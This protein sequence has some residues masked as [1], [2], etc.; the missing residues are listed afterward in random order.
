MFIK[1][2]SGTIAEISLK[3]EKKK[4]NCVGLMILFQDRSYWQVVIMREYF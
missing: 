1:M 4:I 2:A 3:K